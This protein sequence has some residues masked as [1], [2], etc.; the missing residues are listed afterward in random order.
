MFRVSKRRP[1]P[2]MFR[3]C[4]RFSG[5]SLANHRYYRSSGL[6]A[7]SVTTTC[8]WH[9]LSMVL[10][11][12]NVRTYECPRRE[13]VQKMLVDNLLKSVNTGWMAGGLKP[14]N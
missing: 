7:P 13:Y 5:V 1:V 2:F 4:G 8:C 9:E 14:P 3:S 10:T 11:G 12:S 6:V